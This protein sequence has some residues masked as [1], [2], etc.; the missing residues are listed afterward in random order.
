MYRKTFTVYVRA[1][2]YP[3]RTNQVKCI[4]TFDDAFSDNRIPVTF[5]DVYRLIRTLGVAHYGEGTRL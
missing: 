2:N 3:M 5:N 1:K 4:D